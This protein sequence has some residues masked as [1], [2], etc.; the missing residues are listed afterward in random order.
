MSGGAHRARRPTAPQ[1]APALRDARHRPVVLRYAAPPR[2]ERRGWPAVTAVM[3]GVIAVVCAF[4]AVVVAGAWTGITLLNRQTMML[5]AGAPGGPARPGRATPVSPVPF[6]PG[7]ADPGRTGGGAIPPAT[8]NFEDTGPGA[9]DTASVDP[10]TLLTGGEQA[11]VGGEEPL[12]WPSAADRSTVRTNSPPPSPPVGP[13]SPATAAQR[14]APSPTT[15]ASPSPTVPSTERATPP[16]RTPPQSEGHGRTAAP[17]PTRTTEAAGHS[18]KHSPGGSSDA[19]PARKP[20]PQS[21]SSPG[22]AAPGGRR[23]APAETTSA[24]RP[25]LWPGVPTE[26]DDDR[27]ADA[28][29]GVPRHTPG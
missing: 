20:Q 9:I 25:C 13:A 26:P 21:G 17:H 10:R 2:P 22:D 16:T 24:D 14:V 5:D 15:A 1:P 11:V 29:G 27:P 18:V 12:P 7:A 8:E 3:A 6:P 28:A 19:S 23:P 4:G